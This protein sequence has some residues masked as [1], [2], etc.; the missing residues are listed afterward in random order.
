MAA[1]SLLVLL[2]SIFTFFSQNSLAKEDAKSFQKRNFQIDETINPCANFYEYV[3]GKTIKSFELPKTRSIHNFSFDDTK[4]FLLENKKN[5]FTNLKDAKP[6]SERESQLQNYFKACMDEKAGREGELKYVAAIQK[7]LEALQMPAKFTD[8]LFDNLK[9]GRPSFL[10]FNADIP[11]FVNSQKMDVYFEVP[12]LSL[13]EKSYYTK[14]EITQDLIKLAQTFFESLKMDR[15]AERAVWV[16]EFEK[17]LA[18]ASPSQ[19]ELNKRI[20]SLTEYSP[21]LQ[22]KLKNLRV[23]SFIKQLPGNAHIRNIYGDKTYEFV[24]QSLGKLSL[25]QLKSIFLYNVLKSHMDDAYPEFQR[26]MMSFASKYFGKPSERPARL[27]RCTNEIERKFGMELDFVLYPKLFPHFPKEKI[28]AIVEKVRLGLIQSINANSWLSKQAKRSAVLKLQHLNIRLVAPETDQEWNF[29][30]VGSYDVGAPIEN[31]LL[32]AK[33]HY[34]KQIENL[35]QNFSNPVWGFGPLVMNAALLPPYNAIIFPVAF[36]QPPFYDPEVP[37]EVNM[38]A[39]GAVIGHELG[40]AVDDKGYTFDYKGRIR[41]WIKKE[42]EKKFFARVQPLVDQFNNIGHNGKFTL[43]ENIGDLVGLTNAYDV[44]FP[45]GNNKAISLRR[46]F[47]IQWGRSWCEV[48]K[49]EIAELRLKT[50]P[51]SLGIARTNEQVKN[52]PGFAEAFSCK[53]T[54]AMV[55]PKEKLVRIW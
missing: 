25:D 18:K 51:H 31:R 44:A 32:Y 20:F 28:T 10:V 48:Q 1:V 13:P 23:D 21:E 55:L 24:D 53:S 27:E 38:G 4:E 43:G 52:Q 9:S 6:T 3:C 46:D 36:L 22:K 29:N 17:S 2:L 50:D 54:D 47:F 26:Q 42:D 7:E 15:P 35:T 40:H 5:Y 49:P 11:N 12:L 34:E 14:A 41:P 39:I 33:L 45:R 8:Y 19:E 37:D 30:K 16:V